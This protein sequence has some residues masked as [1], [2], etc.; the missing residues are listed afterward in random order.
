MSNKRITS[1]FLHIFWHKSGDFSTQKCINFELGRQWSPKT[2]FWEE[3]L[4]CIKYLEGCSIRK[5]HVFI[6]IKESL[7]VPKSLKLA[8]SFT[9]R[10]DCP[11]KNPQVV[12]FLAYYVFSVKSGLTRSSLSKRPKGSLLVNIG[13]SPNDWVIHFL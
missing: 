1:Y 4:L 12:P 6:D 7:E 9:W 3:F 13:T 5:F 8:D 2:R 11:P 10:S